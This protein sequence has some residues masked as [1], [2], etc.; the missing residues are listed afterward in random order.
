MDR[1]SR[2][3]YQINIDYDRVPDGEKYARNTHRMSIDGVT[4]MVNNAHM[5]GKDIQKSVYKW[6]CRLQ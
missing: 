2:V 1:G 4:T 6:K 5:D 3:E